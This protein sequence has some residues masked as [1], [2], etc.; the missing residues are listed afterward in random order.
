MSDVLLAVAST[1]VVFGGFI[2]LVLLIWKLDKII[3][4]E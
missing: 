3:S 1:F 4:G 2:G